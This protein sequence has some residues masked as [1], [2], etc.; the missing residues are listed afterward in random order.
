MARGRFAKKM[1]TQK[2]WFMI[3]IGVL[4]VLVVVLLVIA[5][6]SNYLLSRLGRLDPDQIPNGSGASEYFDTGVTLEGQEDFTHLDATDV[7]FPEIEDLEGEGVANILLIGVDKASDGYLPRSDSMILITLNTPKR[8][9]QLTSFMRDTYVSIPGYLDNRLNVAYRFG[10][11]ELM[12]ATFNRNFGIT[13]DGNVIVDFDEFAEIVEILGGIDMELS[14]AE[15]D[16]LEEKEGITG[17]TEGVNHLNG[18][19]ALQYC[20]IR[21]VGADDYG[22]TARQRKVLMQIAEGV[23]E[24][25]WLT[26]WRI[27]DELLPHVV[28]NLTD[29]QITEYV[30]TTMSLL[31]HEAELQSLR[32][33]ADD[34]HYGAIVEKMSVLI[35]DLEM[36]RE[37]LEEFIYEI[38]EE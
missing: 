2:L 35:P 27:L 22:R 7:T 18:R 29:Q 17:L 1:E 14:Q 26:I 28:T 11:V 3:A 38:D 12:N 21:N 20:R 9:I 6:V 30:T 34:A 24:T 10:G 13:I 25:D 36:C 32:I 37:D 5:M 8:A 23:R 19:E 16:Y 33:P 31:S 15:V 4:S